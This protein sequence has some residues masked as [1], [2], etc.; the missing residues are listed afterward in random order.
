MN[1]AR[2]PQQALAVFAAVAIPVGCSSAVGQLGPAGPAPQHLSAMQSFGPQGTDSS[3]N[4]YWNKRV[5]RLSY[6]S[7]SHEK[8]TLTYWAP[9]GYYLTPVTCKKAGRISVTPHHRFGNPSGYMHVVYWFT[10]LTPG[11]NGCGISAVLSGTGSPPIAPLRLR[12][13]RS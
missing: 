2:L 1:N 7:S 3:G 11:P 12:I 4:I 9:N 8:A 10:A 6:P 5:L 13:D